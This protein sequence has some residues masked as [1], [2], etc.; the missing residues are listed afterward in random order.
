[1]SCIGITD[2]LN[3]E[4]VE[5]WYSEVRFLDPVCVYDY[6]P[7]QKS[8]KKMEMANLKYDD[9]EVGKYERISSLGVF[10]QKGD[11]VI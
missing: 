3:N 1:M 6:P 8:V 4:L 9:K 7:Q 11:E 10:P 5:V 2:H